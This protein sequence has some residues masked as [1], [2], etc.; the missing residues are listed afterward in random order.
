MLINDTQIFKSSKF[1]LAI[2][3]QNSVHYI[4]C[5]RVIITPENRYFPICEYLKYFN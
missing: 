1:C 2:D 5:D 3:A 4:A